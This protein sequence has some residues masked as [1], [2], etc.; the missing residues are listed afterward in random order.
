MHPTADISP[1]AR[2]G[3]GTT[4]WSHAQIRDGARIGR[5]CVL[6]RNTFVDVDVHVGD[7]VKI[8]NG[9]SLF[10]GVSLADGV[11]VGPHVVFTNDLVPR[12]VNP[13][14]SLKTADDWRRDTTTVGTGAAIGAGAVIITGLHIGEWSM[15]GAGAVV[16]R[17]VPDHALVVGNPARPIGWVDRA[18]MRCA[19]ADVARRRPAAS[20]ARDDG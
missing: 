5:E 3:P 8:Q 4:V 9:A 15:V 18:G 1:T 17:D 20:A 19:A 14:G 6:G 2:I 12:A 13:D 11:F 7:R 10:E 16:T